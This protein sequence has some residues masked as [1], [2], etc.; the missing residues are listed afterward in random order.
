MRMI[1]LAFFCGVTG[2]AD[3]EQRTD[4]KVVELFTS[5]GCSS[6]PPA[7][8]LLGQLTAHDHLLPLAFHVDYWNYLGWEDTLSTSFATQRQEAYREAMGGTFIYTPQF[9]VDGT[10]EFNL[11]QHE[12][13]MDHLAAPT[14]ET[15]QD[16]QGV[17]LTWTKRGLRLTPVRGGLEAGHI[18]LITFLP[19]Q[20]TAITAGENRGHKLT[21]HHAVDHIEVLG[22]WSNEPMTIPLQEPPTY[23][24]AVLVTNADGHIHGAASWTRD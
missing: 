21:Y 9:V 22:D 3:A 15:A 19:A 13:M 6:C 18:W 20:E 17:R 11:R 24:L 10:H 4:L 16:P 1:L 12:V 14:P 23:G 8:Y 7:D 2:S 5:Q